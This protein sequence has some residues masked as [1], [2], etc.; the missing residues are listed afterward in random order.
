[1]KV[2]VTGATGMVGAGALREALADSDVDAVLSIS[3][4]S[5]G[6]SHPKL[7]ELLL[8]DLFDFADVESDLRDGTP[9][10]GQWASARWVSTSGPTRE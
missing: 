9:A 10:S 5:C 1:M 7:R 4:R 8:P 3:R 6:V 2:I